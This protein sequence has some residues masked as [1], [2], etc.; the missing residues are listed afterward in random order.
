[1]PRTGWQIVLGISGAVALVTGAWG[2]KD[3]VLDPPC[4][5]G[6]QTPSPGAEAVA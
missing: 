5:L 1:M 2:M 4:G 6:T 3:G